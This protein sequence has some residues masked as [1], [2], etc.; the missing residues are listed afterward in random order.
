MRRAAVSIPSNIAEGAARRGD[1]EFI[2]Y[3]YTSLGSCMELETQLII[4]K[5]LTFATQED[6][7]KS[8]ST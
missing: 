7:D 6:L 4:S 5:N 8:L 1:K 2:H 3:L